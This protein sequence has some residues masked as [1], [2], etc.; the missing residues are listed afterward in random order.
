MT[1]VEI[2]FRTGRLF[3]LP[4]ESQ[5]YLRCFISLNYFGLLEHPWNL[6]HPLLSSQT[7]VS[8]SCAFRD[9]KQLAAG[10]ES[11]QAHN[12]VPA[13]GH[14]AL[15]ADEGHS[16]NHPH[17]TYGTG[18]CRSGAGLLDAQLRLTVSKRAFG[19]KRAGA[20]V[21]EVAAEGGLE[22]FWP[23]F[24]RIPI[25]KERENFKRNRGRGNVI[26]QP[27]MNRNRLQLWLFTLREGEAAISI[28]FY[29]GNW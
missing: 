26:W 16:P 12:S 28:R 7:L 6:L 27:S 22:R 9:A 15:S 5:H 17:G 23:H 11:S 10:T 13:G 14:S 21:H 1:Y 18:A 25:K 19:A 4:A 29:L 24:L 8:S 2:N 3:L 20:V